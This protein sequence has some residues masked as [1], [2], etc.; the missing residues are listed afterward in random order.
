MLYPLERSLAAVVVSFCFVCTVQA[1]LISPGSTA[2]LDHTTPA[3]S[4]VLLASMSRDFTINS[5][6]D[7]VCSGTVTE[8][9]I[10]ENSGGHLSFEYHVDTTFNPD[11]REP[12]I[13]LTVGH[14][15]TFMTDADGDV[16]I[17]TVYR[18]AASN[19]DLTFNTLWDQLFDYAFVKT[20]ATAF[21][22]GGIVNIYATGGMSSLDG[23]TNLEGFYQPTAIPLPS[24]LGMGLP[25]AAVAAILRRRLRPAC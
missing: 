19:S 2:I 17:D 5:G 24:A 21:T 15:S 7:L 18:S 23:Q 16:E 22:G 9:V 12:W 11:V 10:R 3:P 25:G 8:N 6:T 1:S 4:G 14:F 20:D 13:S